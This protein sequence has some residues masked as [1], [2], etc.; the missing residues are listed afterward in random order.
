MVYWCVFLHKD[1]VCCRATH[2]KQIIDIGF[3][4][5][6]DREKRKSA[7][8]G[9][10]LHVVDESGQVTE[11]KDEKTEQAGTSTSDH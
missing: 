3:L 8:P 2:T 5:D 6:S 4:P 11:Y 10:D 9:I 1:V 7:F